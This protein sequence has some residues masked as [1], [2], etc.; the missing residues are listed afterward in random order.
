MSTQPITNIPAIACT[1]QGGYLIEASAGTGKTWTLTGILLRLLIEKRCPPERIIA[2]TFTRDAAQEIQERLQGRLQAFYQYLQ[3][4]IAKRATHADWFLVGF[5][6]RIDDVMTNIVQTAQQA[7]VASCD[8]PI[9]VHLL[10]KLLSDP[11][12]S[13]L[14]RAVRQVALILSTLDKLFVGTLDSLAQKLL[15]EFA[16][17]MSYDTDTVLISEY[18]SK[19]QIRSLI[20][21][22]LRHEHSV[23]AQMPK[24]AK[25]LPNELFSDVN[26]AYQAVDLALQFY[27]ADI[28]EWHIDV[29]ATLQRFE[30]F[31]D[32]VLAV[33]WSVFEVYADIEYAKQFGLNGTSA[34]TKKF[35]CLK[36]I[37][38]KIHQYRESC[39]EEL[40]KTEKDWLNKCTQ[41]EFDKLFKKGF[42]TQKS[43]FFALPIGVLMALNEWQHRLENLPK[44]YQSALYRKIALNIRQQF[45][46][47]LEKNKQSTFT[48]Q[49]V[50]LT[51]SL[52]NNPSLCRHIRH[53]YPVA[54]IDESQDINGLQLN[55]LRHIYLD[56]MNDHKK[57]FV[58][59]VGDPKQAIY[60][61]RGGDVANYNFV[62]QLTHQGK[63]IF[64]QSLSLIENRRSHQSLIASLNQWFMDNGKISHENP[65]NFGEGIFYQEV[66]SANA[67]AGLSWYDKQ[68]EFDYVGKHALSVLHLKYED[69]ENVFKWLAMHINTL[70]QHHQLNG[71]N[72]IP[73]D[74][75]ILAY[76]HKELN[77]IKKELNQLGIP[78][79]SAKSVNIFHTKS[80]KDIHA[81]LSAMIEPNTQNVGKLLTCGLFDLSLNDAMTMI[82]NANQDYIHVMS[83]LKIAKEKWQ[84][85]GLMSALYHALLNNPLKNS[86]NHQSLNLW[87][88]CAKHGERY[89]ADLWQLLEIIGHQSKNHPHQLYLLSWYQTMFKHPDDKDEYKQ[90]PLPSESGVNLLTMH[91]SKGL[92]FNIVYVLDLDK[93]LYSSNTSLFHPYSDEHFIR[94]IAPSRHKKPLPTRDTDM[95][96]Y[97]LNDEKEQIDE[98]LRLGYVALTRACE[99]LFVVAVDN[100]QAG[101]NLKQRPLYL[102]FDNTDKKELALP[103]RLKNHVDWIELANSEMMTKQHHQ[104]PMQSQ[105]PIV[106]EDWQS[107]FARTTFYGKHRTNATALMNQLG[108][109]KQLQDDMDKEED[110]QFPV[111]INTEDFE[112]LHYAPNDIRLYFERGVNAGTFLH[113][114]LQII[115]PDDDNQISLSINQTIKKLGFNQIYQNDSLNDVPNE[116]HQQLKH[117]LNVIANT[118]M[119]SKATLVQLLSSSKQKPT[120][121]REM[122]FT[123]GL[124]ELFSIDKLNQVLAKYSDK[125]IDIIHEDEFVYEYLNGEI[126]L[127][128]QYQ[129]KFYI[130]DYKSNFVSHQLSHYHTQMLDEVMI[131]SGYWLQAC[132]YQMALHR[133]LSIRIAD[134]VGNEHHYLGGVEFMFLRGIDETNPSWGKISWRLPMELIW[135]LDELFG[136]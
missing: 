76:G 79:I 40:D 34:L 71:Q 107:I 31:I 99:Q 51:E 84:R 120:L 108:K 53:L 13:A 101:Q 21:D 19:E 54:L 114:L 41:E 37:I 124:S 4:L 64:D 18:D 61:F 106:H 115:D 15:R 35:Y 91:K 38:A 116:H 46:H 80:A 128:Y 117:W 110:W 132:I 20:H 134:Y 112:E 77:I 89:L 25:F 81:L 5:V 49:M 48:F 127:V 90:R 12:T 60:R 125:P 44:D 16:S 6:H 118:P 111:F 78:A 67:D 133:L 119:S 14:D 52:A 58:L 97:K 105:T 104:A 26:S 86:P 87:Q 8:D 17:E 22:A 85:Y 136:K 70:L 66:K 98:K 100:H 27:H 33:D 47:Q 121:M 55:L 56:D 3:W 94:R 102:W 43:A 88:Q 42:E 68:G 62:K 75:A 32:D 65:A 11:D 63:P 96:F 7:G 72:I 36:N 83:Y 135:A 28:D 39:F 30:A 24:L 129:G 93:A 23:I 29:H 109:Q 131:K 92:Q 130:V 59:F 57:G 123:L 126:D 73:N 45:K 69:K 10:A 9:H 103:E 82:D 122:S 95:D 1:L 113:E 2:T 74:I 50:R